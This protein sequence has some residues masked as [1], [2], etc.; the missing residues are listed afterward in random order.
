MP[1][2]AR[3]PGSARFVTEPPHEPP[4]FEP[5]DRP[6][7]R[8]DQRRHDNWVLLGVCIV[9]GLIILLVLDLAGAL[10]QSTG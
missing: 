1:H 2:E 8:A 3:P 7:S 6:C 5:E 9:A 4:R 10:R